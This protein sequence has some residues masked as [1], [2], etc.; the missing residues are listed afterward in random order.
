MTIEAEIK[1]TMVPAVDALLLLGARSDEYR[2]FNYDLLRCRKA[3]SAVLARYISSE[4]FAN[5][6]LFQV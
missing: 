1:S 5:L 6:F 4:N 3:K 2:P